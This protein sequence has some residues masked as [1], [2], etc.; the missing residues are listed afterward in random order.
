ML[1]F[2]GAAMAAAVAATIVTVQGAGSPAY[3]VTT[4]KDG[5]VS[6]TVN[7]VE[8]PAEANRELRATTDRVVVIQPSPEAGCSVAE[9][10]TALPVG[11][12][13]AFKMTRVLA[14]S[15]VDNADNA[16]RM[17][18]DHIPAD[19]VLVLV[20]VNAPGGAARLLVSWYKA[21]G[22]KCVVDPFKN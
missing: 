7:R 4:D 11:L 12:A 3:A 21:P 5:T 16:V 13:D 20:P 10:G 1:V 8:D 9:R 22:P 18:P 15:D 6:V 19:A 2:G 14:D 17:R